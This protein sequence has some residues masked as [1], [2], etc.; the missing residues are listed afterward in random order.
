M[1]ATCSGDLSEAAE[2]IM[3]FWDVFI[4][5]VASVAWDEVN[6]YKIIS[7]ITVPPRLM[8]RWTTQQIIDAACCPGCLCEVTCVRC[9]SCRYASKNALFDNTFS[10]V[11]KSIPEAACKN[12][13]ENDI[14]KDSTSKRSR[15]NARDY[16]STFDGLIG[17]GM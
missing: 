7:A 14:L 1:S 3:G 12:S 15:A 17:S 2:I 4:N 6:S 11:S 13:F 10:A 16:H 8:Y 5:S 9:F